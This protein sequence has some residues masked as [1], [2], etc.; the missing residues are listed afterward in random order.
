MLLI[1]RIAARI[2]LSLHVL[3]SLVALFG[4]FALLISISAMWIH[5]PVVIWAAAVNLFGWTCPLTPLEKILWRAG[6]REGYEDGF[7]VHYFGPLINLESTTRRL[8]RLTGAVI[9][10]WNLLLYA[11]FAIAGKGG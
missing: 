5:L 10:G 11:G 6:G 7:L 2:V 3:F 8:E 4:G 1:Y 9:V